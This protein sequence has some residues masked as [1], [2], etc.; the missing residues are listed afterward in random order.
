M[1]S[2]GKFNHES[3]EPLVDAATY[4]VSASIPF[5]LKS[6]SGAKPFYPK[7]HPEVSGT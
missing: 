3:T 4:S 6:T 5:S 7:T 1:F 2:A